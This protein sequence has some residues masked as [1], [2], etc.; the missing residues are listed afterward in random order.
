MGSTRREAPRRGRMLHEAHVRRPRGR[1]TLCPLR[2][3]IM[4]PDLHQRT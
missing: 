2:E 4:F 3:S 1:M